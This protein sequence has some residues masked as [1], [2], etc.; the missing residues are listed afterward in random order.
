MTYGPVEAG[1]QVYSDFIT[2]KSGVYKHISGHLMGGHA[3]KIIGWGTDDGIDS[4][5]CNNSWNSGWGDHG[6]FKILRGVNECGIEGGV[7]GVR[8]KPEMFT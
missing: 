6:T 4:W 7:V 2:Y 1:F 3:V 8:I 5:L